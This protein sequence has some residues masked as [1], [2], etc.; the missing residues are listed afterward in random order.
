[1]PGFSVRVSIHRKAK[2]LGNLYLGAMAWMEP[3]IY[4]LSNYG[5]AG[6]AQFK[7]KVQT[8][9]SKMKQILRACGKCPVEPALAPR[10]TSILWWPVGAEVGKRGKQEH[11]G[12][13]G[14]AHSRHVTS[15][16]KRTRSG[17]QEGKASLLLPR[18]R[19]PSRPQR[20]LPDLWT[21]LLA[22][23]TLPSSPAE[24]LRQTQKWS[25]NL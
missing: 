7:M 2:A 5:A 18:L 19:D 8:G 25:H 23:L 1:M 15:S 9:Q 13:P 21:G 6:T 11:S 17:R 14:T 22:L 24:P 4:S 10:G 12:L 20:M 16:E 3:L